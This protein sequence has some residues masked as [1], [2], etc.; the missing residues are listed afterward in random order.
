MAKKLGTHKG[1]A[2]LHH[3][4]GAVEGEVELGPEVP[5]L[6]FFKCAEIDPACAAKFFPK[7]LV[8]CF[9]GGG[10]YKCAGY[11]LYNNVNAAEM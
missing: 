5:F 9:L 8:G 2:G 7:V 11:S 1:E 6:D 10:W 3:V 4:D